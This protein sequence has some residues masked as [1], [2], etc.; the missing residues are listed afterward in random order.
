[1]YLTSNTYQS[2]RV[3]DALLTACK[4]AN[5]FLV[6]YYFKD[7][8]ISIFC[9]LKYDYICFICSGTAISMVMKY[10]DNI[11]KLKSKGELNPIKGRKKWSNS[12]RNRS[13]TSE[14]LVLQLSDSGF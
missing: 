10:A 2:A 7:L 11:V 12:H 5:I 13:T 4:L 9:F 14:I 1:M 3:Q 8:L 6:K